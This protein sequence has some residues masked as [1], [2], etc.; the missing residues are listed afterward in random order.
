MSKTLF[1][2]KVVSPVAETA[3]LYLRHI[4]MRQGYRQPKYTHLVDQAM[5]RS[6]AEAIERNIAEAERLGNTEFEVVEFEVVAE[7]SAYT[8]GIQGEAAKVAAQH[9]GG[10]VRTYGESVY[11]LRP[12]TGLAEEPQT[13]YFE[14]RLTQGDVIVSAE[15]W[16]LIQDTVRSYISLVADQ[17]TATRLLDIKVSTVE[18]DA[19]EA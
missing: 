14:G 5:V 16:A 11:V 13:G 19:Q 15:D 1:A 18:F 7:Y 9:E 2:A 17:E 12:A 4:G 8:Y 10:F 6:S 3:D